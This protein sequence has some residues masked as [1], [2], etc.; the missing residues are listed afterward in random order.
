MPVSALSAS[1]G[2]NVDL[3]TFRVSRSPD[4]INSYSF[5]RLIPV[6]LTA[7]E[8]RT[9]RGCT[10]IQSAWVA[11]LC[12]MIARSTAGRGFIARIRES[13]QTSKMQLFPQ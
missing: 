5:D 1:N 2:I 9:V 12:A 11:W 10:L 4:W 8:I 6:N 13:T 3:P 7:A